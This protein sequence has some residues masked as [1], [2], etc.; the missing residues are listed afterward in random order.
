MVP[1]NVE[2]EV[3][4]QSMSRWIKNDGK[5]EHEFLPRVSPG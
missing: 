3:W 2:E 5:E 1:N 4:A